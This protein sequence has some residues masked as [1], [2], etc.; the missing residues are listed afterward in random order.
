MLRSPHATRRPTFDHQRC[1]PRQPRPMFETPEPTLWCLGRNCR[2]LHLATCSTGRML[3]WREPAGDCGPRREPSLSVGMGAPLESAAQVSGPT[4][5]STAKPALC[6]NSLTAVSVTGPKLP[7]TTS[8]RLGVRRS[9]RWSQRT[10]PPVAPSEMVGCP[11]FGVQIP[12]VQNKAGNER[13]AWRAPT[14]IYQVSSIL[15]ANA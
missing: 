6:W 11:G 1:H 10:A 4:T 2:R 14:P 15:K 9:A 7:S 13:I 12:F 3:H 8:P 5:P